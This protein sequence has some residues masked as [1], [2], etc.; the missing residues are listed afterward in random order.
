[1][2]L[3]K[4]SSPDLLSRTSI[5][6]PFLPPKKAVFLPLL[7]PPLIPLPHTTGAILQTHVARSGSLLGLKPACKEKRKELVQFGSVPGSG[8]QRG[9]GKVCTST[10]RL[11][12]GSGTGQSQLCWAWFKAIAKRQLNLP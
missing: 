2:L 1:M 9:P 10:R 6:V 12:L 4:E 5:P 7:P 8:L 11:V 3:G